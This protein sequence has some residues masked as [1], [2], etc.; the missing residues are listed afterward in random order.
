MKKIEFL[1]G[2]KF[3]DLDVDTSKLCGVARMMAEQ[4]YTTDNRDDLSRLVIK[5]RYTNEELFKRVIND[6]GDRYDYFEHRNAEKHLQDIENGDPYGEKAFVNSTIYIWD[7]LR[8][9]ESPEDYFNR[10]AEYIE[11]ERQQYL[12]D[13]KPEFSFRVLLHCKR[14]EK[15]ITREAFAKRTEIPLRTLENWEGGVST[16]PAYVQKFVLECLDSIE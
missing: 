8:K 14:E 2:S 4:I 6:S 9:D 11:T 16:P 12:K 5:C 10:H 3:V 13:G 7:A 15:G 1:I